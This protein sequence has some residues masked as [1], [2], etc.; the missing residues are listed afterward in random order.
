MCE[1]HTDSIWA[2]SEF[3][4]MLNQESYCSWIYAKLNFRSSSLASNFATIFKMWGSQFLASFETLTKDQI[5][6]PL[7]EIANE[8]SSEMLFLYN[9]HMPSNHLK[10][11]C[12]DREKLPQNWNKGIFSIKCRTILCY[13]SGIVNEK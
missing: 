2:C 4:V 12:N 8:P 13:T 9:Y 1:E 6:L 10:S 3:T 11:A 7:R 5:Y